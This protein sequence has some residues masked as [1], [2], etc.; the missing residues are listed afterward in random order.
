MK[1]YCYFFTPK[2]GA[3]NHFSVG[4]QMNFGRRLRDPTTKVSINNAFH[5]INLL[6]S[7]HSKLLLLKYTD[8]LES[9]VLWKI[10]VYALK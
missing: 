7:T 10:T 4:T 1:W 5:I 3:F 9:S 6:F 2:A 8:N